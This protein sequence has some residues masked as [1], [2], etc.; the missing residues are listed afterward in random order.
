M[1]WSSGDFDD[2]VEVSA[3][4][5]WDVDT[6]FSEDCTDHEMADSHADGS[7][8]E[9]RAP[10]GLVNVEEDDAGEDDEEGVL[11][12][13]ADEVDIA[14]QASHL[15]HVN[16]LFWAVLSA[17]LSQNIERQGINERICFRNMR[18]KQEW[19]YQDSVDF[20]KE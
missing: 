2:D 14:C 16:N 18:G 8:D 6:V 17:L 19:C 3:D 20:K 7:V 5:A 11:D 9:K 15:K 1:A 12:T 4:T 10:P 13:G